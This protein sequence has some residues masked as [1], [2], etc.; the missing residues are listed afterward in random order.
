MERGCRRGDANGAAAW[1]AA[2]M[3]ALIELLLR[4]RPPYA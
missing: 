2:P 4:P 3:F 1:A